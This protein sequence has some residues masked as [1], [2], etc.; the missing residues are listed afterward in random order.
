MYTLRL[1]S[2]AATTSV[3]SRLTSVR[4]EPLEIGRWMA[5]PS[6]A[7]RST[8]V[9]ASRSSRADSPCRRIDVIRSS[10]TRGRSSSVAPSSDSARRSS[11]RP[12]VWITWRSSPARRSKGR[13]GDSTMTEPG[14][15]P[16]EAAATVATSLYM[17]TATVSTPIRVASCASRGS[18]NPYPLPLRTGT[19]PGCALRT[20][21][22][23]AR[24]R[25][26]STYRLRG[27]AGSAPHGRPT[28][29]V[30]RERPVDQ[31]VE[32]QVPLPGVLHGLAPRAD[33]ELDEA[34]VRVVGVERVGDP[35]QVVD[36]RA[37]RHR[38]ADHRPLDRVG[39]PDLALVGGGGA[40]GVP[41]VRAHPDPDRRG[42]QVLRVVGEV[43]PDAIR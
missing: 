14:N 33:L 4:C 28:L 35:A 34:D 39:A 23:W 43:Q 37:G 18:P 11:R 30:Q 1:G 13:Q 25:G 20:D 2:P 21:S 19:I 40:V 38:V 9:A 10:T 26:P 32:G 42:H 24:Q 8:W 16:P 6:T 7:T 41:G 29:Q 36:L 3:I 27:I 17:P 31:R 15:G 22:R 5:T 12:T